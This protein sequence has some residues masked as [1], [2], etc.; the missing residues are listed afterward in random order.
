MQLLHDSLLLSGRKAAEAGVAAQH[1]LLLLD[2]KIVVL[3]EPFSQVA[4][5]ALSRRG[6]P[7]ICGTRKAWTDIRRAGIPGTR[8]GV[9]GCIVARGIGIRPVLG[10]HGRPALI[11]RPEGWLGPEALGS[12][13]GMGRGGV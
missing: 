5:R 9:A 8:R 13:G 6:I 12:R 1:S 4:R 3:I 10:L 11:G 2:G 7:R